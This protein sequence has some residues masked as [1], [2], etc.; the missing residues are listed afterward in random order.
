MLDYNPFCFV[1][2]RPTDHIAEHDELLEVGMVEY[3]DETG[4]VLTTKKYTEDGARRA[5]EAATA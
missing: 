5:F 4:H 1:C 3:D 2:S